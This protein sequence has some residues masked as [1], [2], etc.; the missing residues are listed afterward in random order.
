MNFSDRAEFKKV[1]LSRRFGFK[2]RWA[3]SNEFTMPNTENVVAVMLPKRT[4]V[5]IFGS[6][7]AIT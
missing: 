1:P 7:I 4:S 2:C 5:Q 6:N 3:D